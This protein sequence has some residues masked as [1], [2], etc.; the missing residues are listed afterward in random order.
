[1]LPLAGAIFTNQN[2]LSYAAWLLV[3]AAHVLLYMT[4]LGV[5]LRAVGENPEAAAT[6]GIGV[7]RTQVIAVL[8]CA[9]FV[10]LPGRYLPIGPLPGFNRAMSAGW[11]WI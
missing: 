9:V 4:P 10:G 8:L 7:V 5:R 1:Q 2:V 3:P 11:G 6:V